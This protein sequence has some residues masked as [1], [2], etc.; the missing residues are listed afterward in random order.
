MRKMAFCRSSAE[1]NVLTCLLPFRR[2]KTPALFFAPAAGR[3]IQWNL[4]C[5][6]IAEQ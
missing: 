4:R 6:Y 2:R 1:P 3:R 5:G